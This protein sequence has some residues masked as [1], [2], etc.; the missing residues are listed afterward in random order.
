MALVV[1]YIQVCKIKIIFVNQV[2]TLHC[3]LLHN[4]FENIFFLQLHHSCLLQLVQEYNYVPYVVVVKNLQNA[5]QKEEKNV[6]FHFVTMEP[7]IMAVLVM[8][9]HMLGAPHLSMEME[10]L[11]VI[12][13]YA[14]QD[15]LNHLRVRNSHYLTWTKKSKLSRKLGTQYAQSN[16]PTNIASSGSFIFG[17][18]QLPKGGGVV[19]FLRIHF[20]P[21]CD[22]F[23]LRF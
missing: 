4:L 5:K 14:R 15:V 10:M 7:T 6:C 12:G 19:I 21:F 1:V 11:V 3:H 18:M 22:Q 17:T 9:H 16:S 2:I 20:G 13:V 8:E 23:F